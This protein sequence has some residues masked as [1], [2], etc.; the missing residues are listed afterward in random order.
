MSNF[1]QPK[2]SKI[3]ALR[4]AYSIADV[5]RIT[6]VG[7]SLLYEEIKEGRLRI[8]KLGRRTLIFDADLRAWLEGL[9][10]KSCGVPQHNKLELEAH[11]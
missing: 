11:E 3:A 10:E 9:P 4:L 8:R 1:E 5:T 7:R 2:S 6:G